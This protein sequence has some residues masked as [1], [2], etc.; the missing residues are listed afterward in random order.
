MARLNQ[1][2]AEAPRP[3]PERAT[4]FF[5]Q[6]AAGKR[7]IAFHSLSTGGCLN[8]NARKESHIHDTNAVIS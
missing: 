1:S 6:A 4:D 8:P 5:A 7:A 3:T 2:K